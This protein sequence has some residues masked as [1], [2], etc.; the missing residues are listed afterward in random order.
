M[1][2][3]KI[4]RE[5][6]ESYATGLRRKLVELQAKGVPITMNVL[7]MASRLLLENRET[8]EDELMMPPADESPEG[9]AREA[10]IRDAIAALERFGE[11]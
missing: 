4:R 6:C 1:D 10:G 2:L 5:A 3:E 8:L 9:Q 11:N 7:A